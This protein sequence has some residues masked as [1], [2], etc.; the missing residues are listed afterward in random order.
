MKIRDRP[1]HIASRLEAGHWERDLVMGKLNKSAVVT[2]V[3]RSSRIL[4]AFPLA[5]GNRSDRLRDRVIEALGQ[6]PFSLR[7][8]PT[9]DRG[10]EM[11]KHADITAALGTQVYFCDPV[12]PWQR[13]SNENANGLLRQYFPKG[14]DLNI[15]D[16]AD[17]RRA[18]NEINDGPRAVLGWASAATKFASLQAAAH[19]FQGAT[20]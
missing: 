5:S 4:M 19:H 17:L 7:R 3:E 14:L 8:T 20:P 9:W 15:I 18:V 12:S 10:A 11:A 16:S 13:G 2:L 6:L 1:A